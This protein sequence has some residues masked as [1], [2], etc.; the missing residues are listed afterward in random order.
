MVFVF[1]YKHQAILLPQNELNLKKSI[2]TI[3][4]NTRNFYYKY[5]LQFA[6]TVVN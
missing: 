5:Y 6:K 1:I 3:F 4:I 2:I